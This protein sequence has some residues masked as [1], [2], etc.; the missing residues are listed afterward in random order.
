[1]NLHPAFSN[2]LTLLVVSAFCMWI[3][4]A[5]LLESSSVVIRGPESP[6]TFPCESVSSPGKS[7]VA[8]FFTG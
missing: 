8:S 5:C 4:E 1:M 6:I 3:V 2:A 7:K